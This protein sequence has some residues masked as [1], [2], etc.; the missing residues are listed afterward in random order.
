MKR[1]KIFVVFGTRPEAIKLAPVIM[2]LK[3]NKKFS[4]KVCVTAQHRQMLDQ[5]LKL[6]FIKPDYDLNIMSKNQRLDQLSAKILLGLT[7][8][9]LKDHP[10]L[11]IVQGD[12]TTTF[13]AALAAFY[14]KI[15]VAHVEA[16]LRSGD[17]INPFPEEINRILT[18]E[19]AEFHFAPTSLA[20]ENLMRM[21]VNE[22]NIVVTGNT[23]IDS[24]LIVKDILS[25]K[26]KAVKWQKFFLD[27][28][29]LDLKNGKKNILVT[30]H[31]RESFGE[32]FKNICNG[33]KKIANNFNNVQIIY[34][35][36]LNPNV[37]KPVKDYL[38]KSKNI[39]LL[40][41]LEYEP[42]I[43]LL[44]K[45]YLVLTDSGGVQE[46]APS[47]GIPVL[48]MRNTTERTEGLIS[49][50]CKL[51]GTDPKQIFNQTKQ[52]LLSND[53]YQK[54]SKAGN[55]YGDGLASIRI[56]KFLEQNI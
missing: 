44:S 48:V 28:Y 30:G 24:L 37:Q 38:S 4:T 11:V 2:E 5:V 35:V 55:P 36:H 51:V 31:R 23:V 18:S 16:G 39:F 54:M 32:G 14:L 12:T 29:N 52:L 47:L 49:G 34:P 43:F 26:E 20:K 3:K 25:K 19:I 33:I 21:G 1:K 13:I 50:N 41:P 42:F 53:L 6:F 17:K 15:P 9:F 56:V 8:I 45:S 40:P 22:K 27:N 10:D 46:E 7:K